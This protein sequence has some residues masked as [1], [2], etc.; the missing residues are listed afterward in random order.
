MQTYEKKKMVRKK[1]HKSTFAST[2]ELE[3]CWVYHLGKRSCLLL[4]IDLWN[5]YLVN[6]SDEKNAN[7]MSDC[8]KNGLGN[9][10]AKIMQL[11]C[12][13]YNS[14]HQFLRKKFHRITEGLR[15]GNNY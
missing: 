8:I 11:C 6:Y 4:K 9:N 5:L 15:E 2:T 12:W 7:E 10:T 14:R 1:P 3:V 13:L